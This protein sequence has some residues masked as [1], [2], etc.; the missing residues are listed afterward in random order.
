MKAIETRVATAIVKAAQWG[1][2]VATIEQKL[3]T[4]IKRKLKEA[5]YEVSYD[6]ARKITIIQWPPLY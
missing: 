1:E 2:F 4:A 5:Q 3:P 6:K